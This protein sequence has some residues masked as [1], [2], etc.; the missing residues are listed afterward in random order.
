M[1]LCALV[2]TGYI[3]LLIQLFIKSFLFITCFFLYYVSNFV[4]LKISS[5][6]LPKYCI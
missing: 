5:L 2:Y 4:L 1:N 6:Y 3:H